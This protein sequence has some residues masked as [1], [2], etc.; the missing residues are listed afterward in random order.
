MPP[1][2]QHRPLHLRGRKPPKPPARR[3]EPFTR[4]RSRSR[5]HSSRGSP[6]NR[7]GEPRNRPGESSNP[8]ESEGAPWNRTRA[9]RPDWVEEG[10]SLDWDCLPGFVRDV[11]VEQAAIE[12]KPSR[13]NNPRLGELWGSSVEH[14][15][16]SKAYRA[17]A[18]ELRHRKRALLASE[19][20]DPNPVITGGYKPYEDPEETH[21]PRAASSV[22][23]SPAGHPAPVG[24]EGYEPPADELNQPQ[25]SKGSLPLL[26][27]EPKPSTNQPKPNGARP[28][29]V[30]ETHFHPFHPTWTGT[31]QRP[32]VVP[33][34]APPRE[35]PDLAPDS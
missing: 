17:S 25:T 29:P 15:Y 27:S 24:R 22:W 21:H 16:Q 12:R 13:R 23:P 18:Y 5:E 35:P 34:P 30:R 7:Q 14:R 10:D 19:A 9:A 3:A 20:A 26:G 4:W 8:S 33:E 11:E 28:R 32:G 2:I 1:R 31:S 6:K